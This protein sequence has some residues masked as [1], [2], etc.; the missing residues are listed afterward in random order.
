M[1]EGITNIISGSEKCICVQMLNMTYYRSRQSFKTSL[2]TYL[3]VNE[4][5]SAEIRNLMLI[6]TSA[7]LPLAML[8]RTKVSLNSKQ[9]LDTCLPTP[10]RVR[11]STPCSLFTFHIIQTLALWEKSLPVKLVKRLQ[12]SP[13]WGI[14]LKK[15]WI[16]KKMQP[17]SPE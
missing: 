11:R 5:S 13:K 4:F 12:T 9:L 2:V 14:P 3:Q 17:L 16:M 7:F 10:W 6:T 8:I 1:I 15:T